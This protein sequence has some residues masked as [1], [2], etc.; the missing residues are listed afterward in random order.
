MAARLEVCADVPFTLTHFRSTKA[1]NIDRDASIFKETFCAHASPRCTLR[2]AAVPCVY[3]SLMLAHFAFLSP[4]PPSCTPDSSTILEPQAPV[5]SFVHVRPCSAPFTP[6]V[7]PLSFLSFSVHISHFITRC[8]APSSILLPTPHMLSLS[9]CA[10]SGT[11]SALTPSL[12]GL[13]SFVL[14]I[15]GTL[16]TASFCTFY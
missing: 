1:C 16:G 5:R 9:R 2:A 6:P 12:G 3:I 7:P 13:H 4:P 10:H 11:F 8:P 14:P 15:G